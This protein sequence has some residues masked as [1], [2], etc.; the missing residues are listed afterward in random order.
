MKLGIILNKFTNSDF[1]LTIN[2]I[3]D[4]WYGGAAELKA[5][6]YYKEYRDKK[7]ISMAILETNN[8][9]ELCIHIAED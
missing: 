9:P 6:S 4:E 3:C 8:M 5:Q 7:V 1:L 2:G